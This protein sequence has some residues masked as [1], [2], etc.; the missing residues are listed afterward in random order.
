MRHRIKAGKVGSFILL[1][2]I[3]TSCAT[4]QEKA[5]RRELM[6][7]AV[8]EAVA[9][10]Q[11]YIDITSMN[12]MRYGTRTVASDFFLEL[13]GDSLRSYLPYLG[14]AYQAPMLSPAQGL[15]F[16]ERI[17]NVK[18]SHPKAKLSQLEI[19][20]RTQED[21]YQYTIE[22][23][24]SGKAYIHVQSQHRDPISF[25]GELVMPGSWGKSNPIS[26]NG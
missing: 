2:L 16:D 1:M 17:Q 20:V 8:V 14:Q 12:T 25:D 7:K 23:H 26:E 22:L 18:E 21:R 13:H 5:E 15:N 24:E 11:M 19:D 4:Q 6:K 10:R 3:F 9:K